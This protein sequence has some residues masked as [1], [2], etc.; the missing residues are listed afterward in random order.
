MWQYSQSRTVVLNTME[1]FFLITQSYIGSSKDQRV[2][3]IV[4]LRGRMTAF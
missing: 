2:D 3:D 1:I 4:H